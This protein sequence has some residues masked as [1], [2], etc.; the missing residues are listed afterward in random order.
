MARSDST[1]ELPPQ[2]TERAAGIEPA[3]TE[4]KTVALPLDDAREIFFQTVLVVL[5]SF[6]FVE[7]LARIALAISCIPG[8]RP[9]IW[10]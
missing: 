4:W 1:T 9:A 5:V 10:A 2:V 6:R 3:S 7:L 8:R